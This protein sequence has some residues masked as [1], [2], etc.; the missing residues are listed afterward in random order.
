MTNLANLVAA[1]LVTGSGT[2]DAAPPVPVPGEDQLRCD[3]AWTYI[4]DVLGRREGRPLVFDDRPDHFHGR[5]PGPTAEWWT[6][7]GPA[8]AP[9]PGLVESLYGQVPDSALA[10]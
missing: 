9:P 10:R 6:R 7:D 8:P 4:E 1:L 2:F 3:A 5:P